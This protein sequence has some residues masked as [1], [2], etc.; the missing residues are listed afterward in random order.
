[1]LLAALYE[2]DLHD[3]SY[4]FRQG[5]SPHGALRA[6]RAQCMG[7]PL[8]WIVDADIRGFFDR[9]DRAL[10]QQVLRE[11]LN[12][13]SLLRLIGKWLQ[14]GVMEDGVLTHPETGVPQGGVRSP[15]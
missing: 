11:R 9:I 1:M 7:K 10:L 14:A 2:Q 4:G 13:G 5:R 6:L 3:C 8:G 12:D 15:V